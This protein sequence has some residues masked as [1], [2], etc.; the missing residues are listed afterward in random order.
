MNIVVREAVMVMYFFNIIY[1]NDSSINVLYDVSVFYLTDKKTSKVLMFWKSFVACSCL[2]S[3][4][5]A[6]SQIK[7]LIYV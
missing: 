4:S 6:A 3:I 1:A 7:K 2:A 5:T